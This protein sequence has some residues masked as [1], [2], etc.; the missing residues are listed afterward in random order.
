VSLY[1]VGTTWYINIQHRGRRLRES[2]RTSDREAA[3]EYHDRRKAELWRTAEFGDPA[4]REFREAVVSWLTE[5]ER[6]LSDRYRL[7]ALPAWLMRR[8]LAAINTAVLDEAIAHMGASSYNRTANLLTAILNHAAARGWMTTVPKLPRRKVDD[9]RVRWLTAEEW[10]RLRAVLPQPW[11]RM[12]RFALATGL[13]ENNVL[14]LRWDQV[15]LS[16]RAAWIHSD[17]AKA[18]DGIGVP[19]NSDAMGV[20]GELD[21][22]ESAW[23]FPNP[24]TGKPYYKAS[25]RT[26]Y[27]CIAEAGLDGLHWHDLRHTWASWH[28]MSGTR[29]EELQRLG[30]WRTFDMVLRY[31]HLAPDYLAPIAE[32]VRP[33]SL[34]R[35]GEA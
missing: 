15:D 14:G 11:E 28:V 25:G 8:K 31:A 12:A 9:R 1:L 33:I 6:D 4:P 26:W 10:E 23:V 22:D 21:P 7:N 32:R 34:K 2:T 19:L 3:Q 18:G 27:R 17:E 16:R 20:L 5:K 29:L 24:T 30:G 13:R 35:S